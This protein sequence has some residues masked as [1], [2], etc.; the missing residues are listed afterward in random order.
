MKTLRK[1][2]YGLAFFV[3]SSALFVPVVFAAKEPGEKCHTKVNMWYEKPEKI[4]STN[5]HRGDMEPVGSQVEILK[6]KENEI[7]FRDIS[8]GIKFKLIRIKKYTNV[9]P[10]ELFARYFSKDSVLGGAGYLRFSQMEKEKIKTGELAVGM[11]KEAVI[12]AYG[13][14]PTHRTQTL[15]QTTW[16]YWKGRLDNFEIK[17]DDKGQVTFIQK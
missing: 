10:D 16:T 13:Y 2:V 6:R 5:Y 9:T 14:P 11:S 1:I 15:E 12:M 8:T 17:F 7:Q 4:Y 3:L